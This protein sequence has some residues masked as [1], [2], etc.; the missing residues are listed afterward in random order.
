ME[1]SADDTN[2]IVGNGDFGMS[3]FCGQF[4][5]KQPPAATV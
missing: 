3:P 5:G 2:T 1:M 4:A